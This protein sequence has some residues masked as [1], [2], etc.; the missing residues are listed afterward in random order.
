MPLPNFNLSVGLIRKNKW[1][2]LCECAGPLKQT[3]FCVWGATDDLIISK[4]PAL[5]CEPLL[6]FGSWWFG[7]THFC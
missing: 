1:K 3:L 5:S 6:I 4:I 7:L 2:H